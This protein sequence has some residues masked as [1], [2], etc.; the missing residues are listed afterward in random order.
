MTVLS[1]NGFLLGGRF[2]QRAPQRRAIRRAGVCEA[3][4]LTSG[5]MLGGPL[6]A[7]VLSAGHSK[8]SLHRQPIYNGN[9]F[10]I[11]IMKII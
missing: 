2:K 10:L 5:H 3:M 9:S 6:Q 4:L 1:R 11:V 8:A 7:V